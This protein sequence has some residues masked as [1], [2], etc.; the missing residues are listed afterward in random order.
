MLIFFFNIEIYKNKLLIKFGLRLNGI[1]VI[2]I[3]N[4]IKSIY[5]LFFLNKKK[6]NKNYKYKVIKMFYDWNENLCVLFLNIL[7]FFYEFYFSI[8]FWMLNVF[9]LIV[10]FNCC[11]MLYF[12]GWRIFFIINKVGWFFCFIFVKKII[13]II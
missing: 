6:I 9:L 8:D 3:F 1:E 10:I 13:L 11:V 5:L 7:D 4:L 12:F 2:K